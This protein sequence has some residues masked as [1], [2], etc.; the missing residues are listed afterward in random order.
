MKKFI[1]IILAV[2]FIIPLVACNEKESKQKTEDKKTSSV[3]ETIDFD[4]S[5]LSTTMAYSQVVEMT[6]NSSKYLGKRVKIT[7][8]FIVEETPQRNYYS[9]LINDQTACCSVGFEFVLKDTNK[10]YPDDYP[11][12][13]GEITVE[14]IFNRYNEGENTYYELIDAVLL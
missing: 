1:A 13:N 14:G 7:G 11:Q 2:F 8:T 9:C 12:S 3:S 6:N 10:S 4:L 5:K